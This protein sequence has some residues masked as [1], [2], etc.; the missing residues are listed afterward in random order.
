MA[1]KEEP[2]PAICSAEQEKVLQHYPVKCGPTA[3]RSSSLAIR[4]VSRSA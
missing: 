1:N 2:R 3:S 4:A